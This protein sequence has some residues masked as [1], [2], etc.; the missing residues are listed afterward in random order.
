MTR[1]AERVGCGGAVTTNRYSPLTSC[2]FASLR[3]QALN[4]ARSPLERWAHSACVPAGVLSVDTNTSA[5]LSPVGLRGDGLPWLR[6]TIT[7]RAEW[8]S[9]RSPPPWKWSQSQTQ[10]PSI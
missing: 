10:E 8:S 5:S 6:W 1:R 9:V 4:R 7:A 2:Q 3:T